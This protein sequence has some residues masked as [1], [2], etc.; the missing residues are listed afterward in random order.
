MFLLGILIGAIIVCV[1]IDYRFFMLHF[2]KNAIAMLIAIILTPFAL[3]YNIL[4]GI[5]HDRRCIDLLKRRGWIQSNKLID[6]QTMWKN[7]QLWTHPEHGEKW[8]GDAYQIETGKKTRLKKLIFNIR[9]R[10]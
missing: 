9:K 8:F 2:T 5:P 6:H 10:K 4:Y 7:P 3:L 1:I